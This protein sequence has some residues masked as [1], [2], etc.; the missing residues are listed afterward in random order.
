MSGVGPR[1]GSEPANPGPPK[2]SVQTGPLCH[3]A[4]PNKYFLSVEYEQ[5]C[6]HLCVT[7]VLHP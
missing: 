4:G 6:E 5:L 2:P 3:W 7:P 1:L